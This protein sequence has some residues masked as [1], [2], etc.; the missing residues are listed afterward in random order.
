MEAATRRSGAHPVGSQ[1]LG[2][3]LQRFNF[4]SKVSW[5]SQ[6]FTHVYTSLNGST[7]EPPWAPTKWRLTNRPTPFVTL[8]RSCLQRNPHIMQDCKEKME[9]PWGSLLSNSPNLKSKT[10]E[11]SEESLQRLRRPLFIIQTT[12][13]SKRQETT[14][15]LSLNQSDRYDLNS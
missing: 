3:K 4:F 8:S 9:R 2:Q 15:L 6:F 11:K 12:Q 14:V 13:L 10:K 5:F 1:G 7:D